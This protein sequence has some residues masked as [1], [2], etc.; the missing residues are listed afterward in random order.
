MRLARITRSLI[1]AGAFACA[2]AKKSTPNAERSP[3]DQA[4]SI[5]LDCYDPAQDGGTWDPNGTAMGAADGRKLDGR[6][7]QFIR[8]KCRDAG[9]TGDAGSGAP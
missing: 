4:K 6:D 2:C 3:R 8:R 7:A 5:G 9:V 1:L